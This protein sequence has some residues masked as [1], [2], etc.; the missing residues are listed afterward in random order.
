MMQPTELQPILRTSLRRRV[1]LAATVVALGHA[2]LPTDAATQDE[3]RLLASLRKAHPG[4]QFTQVARTPVDG[5]YEVWMHGNLAY[6]L[7]RQ[8]RYFVFGHVLDTQ[9]MR[10]L[11]GPKLAQASQATTTTAAAAAPPVSIA[12]DQLPLADAIKTVRGSGLR[13]LAVFSD[14]ACPYCKQ[15]EP[16]LATLD[17]VTV[18][19]FLLPFQGE[20]KPIAIWCAPD[21]V[22]AWQRYMLQGDS[23]AIQGATNCAHPVGRNLA[24]AQRLG[25]QGTP[26]LVWADGGRTE[27]YIERSAIE[28]RLGQSGLEL[29]P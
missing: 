10:D 26:T 2:A 27:G 20:A 15:L 23:T 3:T 5:L 13:K 12:F 4:T 18:Y 17:N 16:E 11:T 22:Q 8:P 28:A 6:V 29:R 25:I 21:R 9:T 14:P 7:A 19:T 1:L 24:L